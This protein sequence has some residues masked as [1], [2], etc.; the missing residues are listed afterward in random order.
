MRSRRQGAC[1]GGGTDG[2][3]DKSRVG[4]GIMLTAEAE[5]PQSEPVD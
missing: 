3:C 2:M 5:D 1:L 4:E